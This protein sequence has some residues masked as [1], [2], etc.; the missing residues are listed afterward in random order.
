MNRGTLTY[1]QSCMAVRQHFTRRLDQM[2]EINLIKA[3]KRICFPLKVTIHCC[4]CLQLPTYQSETWVVHHFQSSFDVFS[5]SCCSLGCAGKY[6]IP[7]RS[8][9]RLITWQKKPFKCITMDGAH[10][11]KD[12]TMDPK[13]EQHNF[14]KI[15]S[16]FIVFASIVEHT[17]Q[18]N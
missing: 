1:I 11:L 8:P 9:I 3:T 17:D 10:P 5:S 15:G 16:I 14:W 4:S 6:F 2:T 18:G 7:T 13:Q 12:S